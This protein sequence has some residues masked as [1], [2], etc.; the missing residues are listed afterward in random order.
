MPIWRRCYNLTKSIIVLL[1]LSLVGYL[2]FLLVVGFFFNAHVVRAAFIRTYL[3]KDTILFEDSISYPIYEDKDI[4]RN[5]EIPMPEVDEYGSFDD[6][7]AGI[8]IFLD[9]FYFEKC[10]N[11]SIY[12]PARP[13][14][15]ANMCLDKGVRGRCNNDAILLN[16]ILQK[17]GFRARNLV[18]DFTDG[19]GGLGHVVVEVWN[20]DENRW[21]LLDAQNLSVFREARM[22]KFLSAFRLRKILLSRDTSLVEVIQYGS[23]WHYPADMLKDYYL[24]EVPLLVLIRNNNFESIYIKSPFM[25]F[26]ERLESS[27]SRMLLLLARFLKVLIVGE[28]RVVYLDEYTPTVSFTVWRNMLMILTAGLLITL[29]IFSFSGALIFWRK[30]DENPDRFR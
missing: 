23:N 16:F 7:I 17:L 19:Y 4:L 5:V 30:D 28:E 11:I 24:W 22:G 12:V 29:V 20:P 9:T 27:H 14:F 21:I 13:S 8:L 1:L 10:K 26:I 2:V 25:P 3:T 15:I 6:M 18:L